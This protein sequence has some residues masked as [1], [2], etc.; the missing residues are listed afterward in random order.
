M[1]CRTRADMTKVASQIGLSIN[2]FKTKCTIN[3]M[4]E[5]KEPEETEVNGQKY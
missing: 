1:Y 5:G 2:A 4:K 3:R